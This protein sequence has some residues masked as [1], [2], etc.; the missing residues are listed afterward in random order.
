MKPARVFLILLMAVWAG[1]VIGVS[2]ISTPVK[3]QAPLLTM[4]AGLDVGRYTFRL[5]SQIELWLVI[6]SLI[7]LF[8]ARP[9]RIVSGAV[10]AVAIIVLVQHNWL[11]P[12]LDARVARILAGQTV[13]PS[14]YHT[15]FAGLEV[16]KSLVLIA[17]AAAGCRPFLWRDGARG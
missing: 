17:G 8:V 12:D 13:G 16:I 7:T 1:I 5:L 10:I 3:F 6:V 11:L 4:Q 2:L 15:I 9:P 14:S